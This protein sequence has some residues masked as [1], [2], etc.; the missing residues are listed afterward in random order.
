MNQ[1]SPVMRR[2]AK[3]LVLLTLAA[4]VAAVIAAPFTP[5][6]DSGRRVG[7]DGGCDVFSVPIF[8][9][10]GYWYQGR[11]RLCPASAT[12]VTQGANAPQP[13]DVLVVSAGR[14][15]AH[16]RNGAGRPHGYFF[17]A[18]KN[19]AFPISPDDE[20]ATFNISLNY[21]N[22]PRDWA[23]LGRALP[24]VPTKFYDLGKAEGVRYVGYSGLKLLP[25]W[26][27]Q[28]APLNENSVVIMMNGFSFRS[29][30]NILGQLAAPF[31]GGMTEQL[32]EVVYLQRDDPTQRL[33]RAFI[34]Q[35]S[36]SQAGQEWERAATDQGARWL[37]SG[38]TRLIKDELGHYIAFA[39][40]LLAAGAVLAGLQALSSGPSGAAT[41]S[42]GDDA[43]GRSGGGGSPPADRRQGQR[44]SQ[45][46]A[47][48]S[49]FYAEPGWG[50]S[51]PKY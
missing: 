16:Q 43:S 37:A 8:D 35:I 13:G 44:K 38:S 45:G 42:S 14:L 12:D 17:R 51:P 33:Y 18:Q 22:A 7:S 29:E 5:A 15:Y 46:V 36:R 2:L 20:W 1:T 26:R 31:A 6:P 41:V 48:I 34:P 49:P 39:G 24:F 50:T 47:P 4:H 28:A 27:R 19:V 23:A 40:A 32:V 3:P 25:S 21:D 10:R 11:V 9:A 30:N